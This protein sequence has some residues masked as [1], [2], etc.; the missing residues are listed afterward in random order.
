MLTNMGE[1]VAK[2]LKVFGSA[3]VVSAALRVIR[4]YHGKLRSSGGVPLKIMNFCGTHE[5]TAVR[6]GIRSLLPDGL[7]LIAGPGCPVC[8]TPG[9]LIDYAVKLSLEGIRVYTFGDALRAPSTSTKTPRS[10][11]EAKAMGAD[12]KVVYSFYDAVLDAKKDRKDAVFLG[13]G[14]ETTAPSYAVPLLEARVPANLKFLSALKLTPP[15]MRYTVKLYKERGLLPIR[16]VIAPGHVSVVTGASAWD[17]LPREFGIATVVSGFDGID[18]L[19]SVAEI[20]RMVA[21]GRPSLYI[22]YRRAVSWD[23]NQ[24]AKKY[25]NEVY[26]VVDSA[27]RGIGYIPGSGLQLKEKFRVYDAYEQ[28]GLKPPGPE[29]YVLTTAKLYTDVDLPPAC[30]CGEIVLGIVT[31]TQCPMFMKSCTPER[32]YGPCMVSQEGTCYIWAKYG[33]VGVGVLRGGLRSQ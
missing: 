23:G 1:D 10:L 17:F 31:P 33:G 4:D 5:W 26:E 3:E 2:L 21:E 27:W 16:G 11:A 6:Y 18:L 12:V 25:I 13:I 32:P 15:I 30:R 19:V 24:V 7:D 28:Y 22:E 20:V 9:P 8:V 14:F 29:G